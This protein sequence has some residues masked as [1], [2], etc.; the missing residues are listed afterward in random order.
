MTMYY[1]VGM[2]LGGRSRHVRVEAEDALIAALKVKH[3]HPAAAITYVRKSN[4]RGDHRHP[5]FQYPE[6]T[7]RD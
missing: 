7:E 3:G 6:M 5:Q 4:V 1:T 2:T